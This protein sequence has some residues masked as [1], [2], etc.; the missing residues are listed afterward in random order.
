MSIE[1]LRQAIDSTRRVVAGVA[2]E[3]FSDDTPCA[4]WTV[5]E[6]IDH[7][8][9]AQIFFSSAIE[10]IAAPETGA[11]PSAGD[12]LASYDEA[13]AGLLAALSVDGI[14]QK[15]ISMPFGDMPGSAVT[16]IVANDVFVHGWDLAR[17]TGQS[18]DLAPELAGLFLER[19]RASLQESL[20]GDE[21]A[22][23]GH[24]CQAPDGAC[25]ADQ[26]AAFLGRSV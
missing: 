6:L 24:E 12:Y 10:G 19:S 5:A 14:M 20:R 18:T 16:G 13:S 21:G 1:P 8:V 3:Q 17:A 26:L 2:A 23:F 22:P 15:T 7:I 11:D 4:S 25:K 9:G